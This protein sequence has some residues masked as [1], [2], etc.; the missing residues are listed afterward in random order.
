MPVQWLYNR[1]RTRP[2]FPEPSFMCCRTLSTNQNSCNFSFGCK[3]G[4]QHWVTFSFQPD[5]S[6]L[7]WRQ[8][9]PVQGWHCWRAPLLP[10]GNFFL[11]SENGMFSEKT[12]KALPQQAP[13][14]SLRKKKKKSFIRVSQLTF[15]KTSCFCLWLCVLVVRL[16]ALG[17]FYLMSS[18]EAFSHLL[19]SD[20]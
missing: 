2:A 3:L 17:T 8:A 10:L 9:N 7:F 15:N 6:P 13:S 14:L 11:P 12:P 20:H 1:A 5:D 4:H 18:S 19:G 16:P